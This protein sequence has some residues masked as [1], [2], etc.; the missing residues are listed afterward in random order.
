M[1]PVRLRC[2]RKEMTRVEEVEG[3]RPHSTG[4]RESELRSHGETSPP[5]FRPLPS[6][7]G[8]VVLNARPQIGIWSQPQ[9]EEGSKLSVSPRTLLL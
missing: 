3:S 6:F 1:L 2:D 9:E 8:L 5:C 4:I 7:P